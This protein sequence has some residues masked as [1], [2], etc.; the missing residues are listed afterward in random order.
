MCKVIHIS[1]YRCSS[2]FCLYID[3]Y[4]IRSYACQWT[5]TSYM[6]TCLRTLGY[7]C[8]CASCIFMRIETCLLHVQANVYTH[9]YVCTLMQVVCTEI[10]I[11]IICFAI[12]GENIK[13]YI[14]I[15]KYIYICIGLYVLMYLFMC[16][17]SHVSALYP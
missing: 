2:M 17:Y 3:L 15:L 11:A 4:M 10:C 5:M 14:G 16:M 12:I 13:I 1:L 6:L 8:I 7:V 9:V